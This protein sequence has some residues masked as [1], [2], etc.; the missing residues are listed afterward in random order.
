MT[1][2]ENLRKALHGRSRRR[3]LA[4]LG[5]RPV[6]SQSP[7]PLRSSE[8]TRGLPLTRPLLCLLSCE[9]DFQFISSVTAAIG[10]A[11]ESEPT[12]VNLNC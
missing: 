9:G 1:R 5:L 2:S 10:D 7:E 4:S 8:R 3:L 12:A 11:T 6:A